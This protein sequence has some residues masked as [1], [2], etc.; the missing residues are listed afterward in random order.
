LPFVAVICPKL[1]SGACENGLR[2][3]GSPPNATVFGKLQMVQDVE[4]FSAELH[5]AS[6]P[7]QSH[8]RILDQREVPIPWRRPAHDV[9]P[10]FSS[11]APGQ[12]CGA[13]DTRSF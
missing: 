7:K 6:L 4:D 8:H 10:I 12:F 3:V 11:S 9:N 13:V 2:K 5:R 1:D